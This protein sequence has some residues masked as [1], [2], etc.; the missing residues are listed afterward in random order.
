MG[1]KRDEEDEGK[2]ERALDGG[3]RVAVAVTGRVCIK[4]EADVEFGE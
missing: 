2:D 4:V 1:A 3:A